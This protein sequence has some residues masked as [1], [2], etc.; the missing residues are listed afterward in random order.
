MCSNIITHRNGLFRRVEFQLAAVAA[1]GAHSWQH[2]KKT[3]LYIRLSFFD[4]GRI[5]PVCAPGWLADV[6][7]KSP[8]QL[9][10]KIEREFGAET[11]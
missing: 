7:N 8:N 6:G 2:Q 5:Q 4:V 9:Y 10:R 1:G 3:G 11:L